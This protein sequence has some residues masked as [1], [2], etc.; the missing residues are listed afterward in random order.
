MFLLLK[1]CLFSSL[2]GSGL[3]GSSLFNNGGCGVVSY[4]VNS[5]SSLFNNGYYSV[6][7]S[8]FLSV[9]CFVAARDHRETS[10]HSERKK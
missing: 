1:L 9:L 5:N 3:S 4:G 8:C 6:F 2:S 10:E 7:S